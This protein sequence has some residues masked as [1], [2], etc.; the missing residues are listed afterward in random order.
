M[1]IEPNVTPVTVNGKLVHFKNWVLSLGDG[2]TPTYAFDDDIE[3]SWVK[4]PKVVQ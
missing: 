1:S 2:L 3:P 4:I